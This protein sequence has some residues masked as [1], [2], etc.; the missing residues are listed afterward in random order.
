MK[1]DCLC[2]N[3]LYDQTDSIPYKAYCVA[4]QD[5]EGLA[6]DIGKQLAATL[7]PALA[8]PKGAD[9]AQLLGDAL[10]NAMG[11]CTRAIFINATT[12]A[13]FAL[14]P[15]ITRGSCNGSG[16]KMTSRWKLALASIKGEASKVWMRNLVGDWDTSRSQGRLW[17][18][19]PPGEKGGYEV[20]A[21]RASFERRYYELFGLLKAEGRLAGGSPGCKR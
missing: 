9:L 17:F 2:G 18:D 11:A 16:P 8:A 20:F 15:R 10:M 13:D 5:Y 19:P 7:A 3:T 12:A 21:D 4:D 14:T 1:I 6:E